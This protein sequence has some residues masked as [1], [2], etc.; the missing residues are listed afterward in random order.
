MS[1]V[2]QARTDPVFTGTFKKRVVTRVYGN[3][4]WAGLYVDGK[5]IHQ[6]HSIP[7]SYLDDF[8][9]VLGTILEEAEYDA[10]WMDEVTTLPEHLEDVKLV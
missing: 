1:G 5:L 10:A 9:S 6:G 3:S 2:E 7:P 4:D 8:C